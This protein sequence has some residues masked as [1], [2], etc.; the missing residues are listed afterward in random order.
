[1][2]APF[3]LPEPAVHAVHYPGR[4][5]DL[6]RP[7]TAEQ[8]RRVRARPGAAAASRPGAA[9]PDGAGTARACVDG[10]GRRGHLARLARHSRDTALDR[11]GPLVAFQLRLSL[12]PYR[13]DVLHAA[14]RHGS[15]EA[16]GAGEL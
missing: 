6:G 9:G 3:A 10:E 14:V 13:R 15:V 1:M 8:R 16:A 4:D 12:G 7:P 11:P 2:A 5:S